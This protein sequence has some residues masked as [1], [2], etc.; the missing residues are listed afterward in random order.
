MRKGQNT[1]ASRCRAQINSLAEEINK[2]SQRLISKRSLIKGTIYDSRRRCGY[3]NCKCAKSGQLHSSPVLSFSHKG[4]AKSV[5]LS[6]Y[7][8]EEFQEIKRRVEDYRQFRQ[9]RA[10]IVQYFSE[11]VEQINSLEEALLT[12]V[13]P[14]RKISKGGV[15]RNDR[16]KR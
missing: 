2:L 12:E 3:K 6:K 13:S 9:C 8:S 1:Q 15:D 7:S 11:L 10:K 16:K 14:A 5:G 4:K